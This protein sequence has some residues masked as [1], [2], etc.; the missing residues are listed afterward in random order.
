MM[1]KTPRLSELQR[2]LL[3]TASQR[4]DGSLLPPPD[5]IGEATAKIEKAIASLVRRGLAQHLNG[6]EDGNVQVRISDAGWALIGTGEKPNA[7]AH[8]APISAASAHAPGTTKTSQ[9][10]AMLERENG[11]TLNEL[12]AA[13]GWLPHTTRAALTGLRRKGHA[14]ASEKID[15]LRRYRVIRADAPE[16]SA[17]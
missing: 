17:R 14:L 10:L 13:T 1:S 5:V 4:Q 15:G 16:L 7:P 2:V 6:S 9:V 11:T 3:N 12:V 8:A